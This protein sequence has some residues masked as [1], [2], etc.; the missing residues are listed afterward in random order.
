M[1]PPKAPGPAPVV[2]SAGLKAD[3]DVSDDCS[4]FCSNG[5][6]NVIRINKGTCESSYEHK[7]NNECIKIE[8]N[9]ATITENECNVSNSSRVPHQTKEK[10]EVISKIL[11]LF[12][13]DIMERFLFFI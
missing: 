4:R 1:F 13:F 11:H 7:C 9:T 6:I 12:S 3:D 8:R 10:N 2:T 5:R